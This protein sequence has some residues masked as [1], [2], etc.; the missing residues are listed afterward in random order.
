MSSFSTRNPVLAHA[1]EKPQPY[2]N[3]EQ[4]AAAPKVMT[5]GGTVNAAFTL[6]CLCAAGAIGGWMLVQNGIIG[7]MP[8]WIG[9][10]IGG[11]VLSLIISFK[12]T[13][14]PFL[15]PVYAAI[16]GL[17]LGGFSL[18]V[19]ETLD[20]RL[21]NGVGSQTV[22]QA[23]ILT[24]G[25]FAAM[26]LA[27]K[28]GLIR[29]GPI[30]R[31]IIAVGAMGYMLFFVVALVMSLFGQSTLISVFDIQNGSPISILF[32]VAVCALAAFSLIVDFDFID[33]GAKQGL[34]KHMEWYGAF[35]L[36]V[37]LVWLYFE[38]LRLLAKLKSSE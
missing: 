11:I 16:Q 22:F 26:L 23:I 38:I 10:M 8:L 9:A 17:F 37:T 18:F 27:Y 24:L 36:T 31:R 21:G 4:A 2:G 34:P 33:Q 19:A 12:T 5:I 13:T 7:M 1:F 29:S 25:V 15:G 3:L 20:A 28:T 14:A 6:L 32:S 35:A 30:F